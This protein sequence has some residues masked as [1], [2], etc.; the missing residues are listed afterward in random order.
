M[1]KSV[2]Y[3]IAQQSH[4]QMMSFLIVS[5]NGQ[6]TVIDGG[7]PAD[8][9]YLLHLMKEIS[10]SKT[11]HI[12]AW[13]L[14]HAHSDHVGAFFELYQNH[15][16]QFTVGRIYHHFPAPGFIMANEP[17]S[18]ETIR[19][20]HQLLPLYQDKIHIVETGECIQVDNLCFEIL[21]VTD[22]AFTMNAL[23]NS[24]TVIR[25][26][27]EGV[28][29]MFLGDLG[30]EGGQKLLQTQPVEKIK[31]DIV[32]LAHHGQSGVDFPV[33]A[34][35]GPKLALWCTPRWLWENNQG[36]RGP[37]SGPWKIDE[38]RGWL[39][40][41]GVKDHLI[42]KDGTFRITLSGGAYTTRLYDS[43]AMN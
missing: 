43:F 19:T 30:V 25:L 34:A 27:T 40:K 28:S 6:M 20:F 17:A 4:I 29:V 35:I 26:T 22:P 32:E 39:E 41:I 7:K 12:Q 16:S 1:E 11:P 10:G 42:S 23:N 8:A 3:Q 36:S 24:S 37:G 31:S 9:I 33:Y 13:F 18:Y 15:L 2:I 14:T 5:G 38:T 21:Y